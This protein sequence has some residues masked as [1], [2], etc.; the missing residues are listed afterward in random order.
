MNENQKEIF[1]KIVYTFSSLAGV[2]DKE[3]IDNFVNKASTYNEENAI[4]VLIISINNLINGKKLTLEQIYDNADLLTSL[5]DSYKTIDSFIN[6]LEYLRSMNLVNKETSLEENHKLVLEAFD[7]FNSLIGTNLDTYYV[8]GLMVYLAIN[9]P[10]ERY[11]G[12]IDMFINEQQLSNLMNILKDNED[13]HFVSNMDHKEENGHEYK[14]QYKDSPMSIGLFL[15][16]RKENNELVIKDYF[17]KDNNLLCNE[18]HLSASYAALAFSSNIMNHNGI[19][20]RMQ[21][22]ESIYNSKKNSRPKDKYDAELI[23]DYVDIMID[24]QMDN[25]KLNNYWKQN[26]DASN[27]VVAQIEEEL[28]SNKSNSL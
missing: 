24:F 14:I 25:E 9:R 1:K 2:N 7:R 23:K 28:S 10:L 21:S 4:D 16:E 17:Y 11:H 6:R 12:D 20:F 22:L 18:K 15:F 5:S 26:V 27:S 8:G 13:F 19:P 3:V